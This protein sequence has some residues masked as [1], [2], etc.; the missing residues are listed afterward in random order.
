MMIFRFKYT[1]TS[2]PAMKIA[3]FAGQKHFIMELLIIMIAVIAV[4]IIAS[5]EGIWHA[6][7]LDANDVNF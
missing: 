1:Q 2:Q 4:G 7:E 6:G 3:G 5:V